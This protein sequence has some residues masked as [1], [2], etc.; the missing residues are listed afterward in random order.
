V[1]RSTSKHRTTARHPRR[2]RSLHVEALEVRRVLAVAWRNPVDAV[3]VDADRFV[4][5]R[6]AL[7]IINYLNESHPA[8]LPPVHN[9]DQP[10][11]DTNGDQAAT[12]ID[13]L[14]VINHLNRHS[15]G[16]RQLLENRGFA[17]ETDVIVTTGQTSGART[18]QVRLDF[19]F[20][21]TDGSSVLED[22]L[23][24]YVV[25]PKQTSQTLMDRGT[26]GTSV[27][28]L[29][30]SRVE[31]ASGIARWDGS[32]LT[33]DSSSLA[34]R[35]TALLRFQLINGDADN[36]TRITVEPL[37]NQVD[38]SATP[39]LYTPSTTNVLAPSGPLTMTPGLPTQDVS[40]AL[41][42]VR[43]D[44]VSGILTTDARLINDGNT[45]GR[46]LIAAF[47]HL[48]VGVELRH[49]SGTL[50]DGTPYINFRSAITNGGLKT[51]ATT[52]AVSIEFNN[53][54]QR[55]VALQAQILAKPNDAPQLEP[56][57][58]VTMTMGDI[59][60][61]PLRAT[62]ADGDHIEYAVDDVSK[63]PGGELRADGKLILHPS[64]IQA[65]SYGFQILASDGSS[66]A[67]QSVT[68]NVL[69]DALTTTRISG[70]VMNTNG[71]P[72]NGVRV[73]VG[74]VV[75]LTNSLGAF[76]LDLGS[77]AS[78]SD[79]LKVR[80][81]MLTGSLAYP[82]IAEKL[83]LVLDGPV[84]P[85]TNNV[86]QR[87][88][89]LP[90]LDLANGKVIDPS[91]ST[92]VTTAA[93]PDLSIT[94]NA[95][96]LFNQQGS[97]Y[98]GV[99]S[100]TQ[101][102]PDLT[103]AALPANLRPDLVV[104]VQPGEMVFATPAPM[105]FPNLAGWAPGTL[106]DLW[107]INPVT[108]AFDDVGDMRVINNGRTIDTISGG[109]R[110]SSWHFA[111]P[112]APVAKPVADDPRNPKIGCNQ[113]VMALDTS[114]FEIELHSGAVHETHTLVGYQSL[115]VERALQ[116]R[117]DSLRADPRPILHFGYDNAIGDDQQ[118]L[119]AQLSISSEQGFTYEVP[120]ATSVG[121]GIPS[122]AHFWRLPT[123][124]ATVDA[125]LQADL[126]SAPTGT[127]TYQL[128][129]GIVRY[130]DA[131]IV[132]STTSQ[133]GRW[134]HI[135]TIDS[136]LGSG[137]GIAG[138]QELIE[139][140]DGSVLLFDGDGSELIFDAPT[141]GSNQYQSPPGDFSTLHRQLDGTYLR[142]FR[143]QATTR[144]DA[145]GKLLLATDRQGNQTSYEYIDGKLV[146]ILDPAGLATQLHYSA[147]RLTSIVDPAGR[148]TL[149]QFDAQGNLRSITDPDGQSRSMTT[150][151]I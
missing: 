31:V 36:G 101:V 80:G 13:A 88:I 35:D 68:V 39:S 29:S 64:G 59:V 124:R 67:R 6:D 12:P 141:S 11:L 89:Y 102:P 150:N 3:D 94:V 8:S 129:S 51:G 103:P 108:G 60:E 95:G 26:K 17:T 44:V 114:A 10:Y 14:L 136:P 58:P 138:I 30:E 43:F 18:I 151:I 130:D 121:G 75:G 45:V 87:P 55:R 52:E 110:N 37:F 16:P 46:E 27:F 5:P 105:S 62:D 84:V 79:T 74:S 33:I 61:I 96:T 91:K 120:G 100:L 53:P 125:A 49:A 40:I 77:G 83:Q 147:Q 73:E 115:G 135:N 20:D 128:T 111:A 133:T 118:R 144:F 145:D 65:G 132:G 48:P 142:R 56:I 22:R 24:V 57:G 149:L 19:D 117:Y 42:N 116:L 107:S 28:A 70:H 148:T 92:K 69:A 25:D 15:G 104:T 2:R 78:S 71:Q 38:I 82:F 113:C 109:V 76:Q 21:T 139:N 127:Y 119:M 72:M 86:I 122:G 98:T 140:A 63:V 112:P 143:D 9:L 81:E 54:A 93:V 99:L 1:S 134:L 126:R 106:M 146:R 32:V 50:G 137:W 4:V 123:A 47:P 90:A 7:Q 41:E 23:A 131:R 34:N 85:N 97:P 66:V